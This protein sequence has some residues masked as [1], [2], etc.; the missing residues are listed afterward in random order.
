MSSIC[1]IHIST[2]ASWRGGEQQLAY[3]VRALSE[4]GVNQEVLCRKDAPF[5]DYCR[6]M[7]IRYM[8]FNNTGSLNVH[9]AWILTRR[10]KTRHNCLVHCHD[11]HAHSIAYIAALLFRN[12]SPV[13]VHRRVDFPVGKSFFSK[14]K[15]NHPAIAR[16]ICV[17]GAI[18]DILIPSLRFPEKAVVIH[19]GIDLERFANTE[20]NHTLRK[21]FGLSGKHIL[22]GNI[23]ALAPHKDYYT[24]VQT[25]SILINKKPE[26]RFFIIGDGPEMNSIKYYVSGLGLENKVFFT[27]FRKNIPE[28]IKELNVLLLTSK[29]EGL[30]T[31]ILD[32][33][34]GGLPVVATRAGGIPEIV[35]HRKTGLLA[36]VGCASELADMVEMILNKKQLA[37]ELVINALQKVKD[38]EYTHTAARIFRQ[39]KDVLNAG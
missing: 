25:A 21:E 17:S 13:I 23:A 15:Y 31:T 7:N 22:I 29:T 26:L 36:K 19:S 20:D 11:S 8:E 35:E 3:L 4:M 12:K 33:F 30:G 24:F 5:A 10:C 38:Y 18:R 6:K 1:V 9:A 34:A 27:G 14:T 32:A 2:A 39:Y 37:E 28:L 16:Y